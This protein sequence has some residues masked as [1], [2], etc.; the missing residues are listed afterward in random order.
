MAK[1][2]NRF[3]TGDI[4]TIHDNLLCDLYSLNR[5]GGFEWK[6]FNG[7]QYLINQKQGRGYTIGLRVKVPDELLIIDG[8]KCKFDDLDSDTVEE[9]EDKL[10]SRLYFSNIEIY[11][12]NMLFDKFLRYG[13]NCNI[14]IQE[15][16]GYYRKGK[17]DYRKVRVM[18]NVYDR[19]IETLKLLVEKELFLETNASFRNDKYGARNINFSHMFLS[20][21]QIE[22]LEMNN[23]KFNYSFH[24]FGNVIKQ[25]RRYSNT[26]S[27]YAFKIR[28]NQAMKYVTSFFI[29]RDVF[30]AKGN[31][32]HNPSYIYNEMTVTS[33]SY[34]KE[35]KYD[36]RKNNN[37]GYSMSYKLNSFKGIPNK[38]R[39]KKMFIN[40]IK[41]GF[42]LCNVFSIEEQFSY[43]ETEEFVEKHEFDYDEN[44]NLNYNFSLD[45]LGQD[46]N[47]SL[48][49]YID[50]PDNFYDYVF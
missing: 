37:Q 6:E 7:N 8:A 27:R 22:Q 15:M 50:D 48:L 25:C 16:D 31:L 23:M 30:I 32:I 39:I 5:D 29:A 3:T 40:Y 41:R 36:G 34:E 43:D 1:I 42:Y 19:Y 11:V 45:D 9:I 26:L 2:R 49:V 38:I 12:A 47:V 24:N 28:F 21:F 46:V 14:S 20:V 17:K 4:I 33:E 44:Y 18:K 35:V 13:N 10:S